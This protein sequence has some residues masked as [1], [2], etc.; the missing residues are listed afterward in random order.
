M[1]IKTFV[2]KNHTIRELSRKQDILHLGCV[3]FTDCPHEI[4]TKRAQESLHAELTKVGN[5]TGVDIDSDT[6]NE[7]RN[8]GIFDNVIEG[9]VE[10]LENIAKQLQHY[11][12]VI[13]G[14]IIEHVSNPGLMLDGIKPFLKSSG[15]LV[16][17]TPNAFGIA[18]YIRF[19]LCK[20]REG[21]Q[22][23]MCFNSIT[24]QQLLERHGYE[25]IHAQTCYQDIAKEKYGF[26]FGLFK[27]LLTRF[28]RFGGTLMYTCQLRS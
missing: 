14:D 24:L 13:A 5:C 8:A 18:A 4:K 17:S 27:F 16:V 25:I 15:K 22:H 10:H 19:I 21:E 20:F 12:I 6:I 1:R 7:L 23:V 28:P 3:G 2:G 26:F 11:D 9:N